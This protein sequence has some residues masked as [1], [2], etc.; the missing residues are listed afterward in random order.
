M[1][2]LKS[3]PCAALADADLSA[4]TTI[5][6]GGRA[7][8][9]LEP[10]TPEELVARLR[11]AGVDAEF[12]GDPLSSAKKLVAGLCGQSAAL[13]LGAGDIDLVQ[14]DLLEELA[15]RGPGGRG[16]R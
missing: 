11:K 8:W 13:I 5:G 4:R 12:G 1:T 15:V 9:L 2:S 3:W 6:V 10:A 7:R 14:D 16:A